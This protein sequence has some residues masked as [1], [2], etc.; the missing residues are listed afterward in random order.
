MVNIKLT[1]NTS[2][3][4]GSVSKLACRTY[5]LQAY[6]SVVTF[7]TYLDAYLLL[8]YTKFK[9]N[10]HYVKLLVFNGSVLRQSR[11]IYVEIDSY[12]GTMK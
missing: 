6:K 2:N 7:L 10:T 11:H 9:T 12:Y 8:T 5:R 1:N 4:S 3:L